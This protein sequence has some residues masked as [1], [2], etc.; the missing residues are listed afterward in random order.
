M[1]IVEN[2]PLPNLKDDFMDFELAVS[3]S[4]HLSIS[5]FSDPRKLMV[6]SIYSYLGTYDSFFPVLQKIAPSFL[7]MCLPSRSYPPTSLRSLLL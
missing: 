7:K 4:I 3:A 6:I 5:L 1:N 2:P